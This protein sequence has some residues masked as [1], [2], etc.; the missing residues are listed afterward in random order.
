MIYFL[1]HYSFSS[2]PE[3]PSE[4]WVL[5]QKQGLRDPRRQPDES[6]M[7]LYRPLCYH[8]NSVGPRTVAYCL[9]AQSLS[10]VLLFVT[11]WIA[12]HQASLSITI[13]RNSLK[14]TSIESVMPSSYLILCHS[15]LLLPPS[16]P[17][18]ESF[19]VSQFFAWGGQRITNHKKPVRLFQRRQSFKR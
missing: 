14:L 9:R 19:P 17:A 16:L 6:L 11:P 3:T 7:F 10:H 13:S 8:R 4:V 12:A 2:Y 1:P 5:V 15:L 18:S